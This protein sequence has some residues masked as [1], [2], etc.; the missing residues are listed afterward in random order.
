MYN[1][2][3][4][5]S[6]TVKAVLERFPKA[7]T[8]TLARKLYKENPL[9]F[10]SV[11]SARNNV[12][13]WRGAIGETHRKKL[14]SEAFV[15]SK[16]EAEAK[17][18]NPFGLPDSQADDWKPIDFPIKKGR[19][20]VIADMHIPYQDNDALTLA[21]QWAKR[22]GYVDFVLILGDFQDCYALSRFEKDPRKRR[23]KQEIED[24]NTFFDVLEK[25]FPKG[26]KII[27]CGNHEYRLLR[28]L[29]AKAPEIFDLDE[30]DW[31][32]LLGIEK[33]GFIP[34]EHDVYMK[35]GKLNIMHGHEL[36]G[37]SATV[38]PA[39]GVYLKT[40]E[41][42]LAA[43]WHRTSTHAETSLNRRLDTAWSIGCT[44]CLWPEY[45]RVNKW[46]HGLA[47]LEVD[48]DD[49]EI[50]NKRIVKGLVR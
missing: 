21:M 8:M 33:R 17:R 9:L 19:G 27:K 23:Y 7:A 46:N 31:K 26:K 14:K 6:Q 13:Y 50:E 42:I 34:V 28:Y 24:V 29:Q 41:C 39:R 5:T 3:S 20:L 10:N 47:G 36:G 16:A 22:E 35:V 18:K 45:S 12:R 2:D 11:E 43:H 30:I 40:H 44:C 25:Q 1:R 48:G 15:R 38:N 4:I 37:A 32:N 49:F